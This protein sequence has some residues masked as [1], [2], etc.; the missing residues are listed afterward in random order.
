[1]KIVLTT[2]DKYLFLLPTYASLF[3]R[4]WPNQRVTVLCFD[5]P[6]RLPA[7]FDCISMGKQVDY[8]RTWSDPVRQYIKQVSDTA[9][10]LLLDD[11]FL[12]DYVNEK[13]ITEATNLVESNKATK[14]LVGLRYDNARPYNKNFAV[15]NNKIRASV[16]LKPSIWRREYLLSLLRPSFNIW[17]V[18]Q[19]NRHKSQEPPKKVMQPRNTVIFNNFNLMI[20]G[21]LKSPEELLSASWPDKTSYVS[22]QPIAV[23]EIQRLYETRK[24]MI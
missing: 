8:G 20:K 16:T 1:M 5:M 15:C 3:N 12:M 22:W 21:Q 24:G 4:F 10:L 18:E 7:N 13:Y 2:S 9:I 11:L 14:V 19:K 23:Q 6:P 17:K